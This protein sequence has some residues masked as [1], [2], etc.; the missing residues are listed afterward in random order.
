MKT[1]SQFVKESATSPVLSKSVGTAA[2][3]PAHA[4]NGKKPGA[5]QPKARIILPISEIKGLR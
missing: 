1:F 3:D 4:G 5:A 2:A